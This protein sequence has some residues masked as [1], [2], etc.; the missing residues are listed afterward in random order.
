MSSDIVLR[1]AAQAKAASPETTADLDG[2]FRI[3][4][5]QLLRYFARRLGPEDA[6]DLA[7]ETFLR[8]A[9]LAAPQALDNPAAYLQRIARNLLRDR[10]KNATAARERTHLT[11]EPELHAANDGDPH[12]ALVARQTLERYEAA[13]MKLKPKTREIYLRHR[14]DGVSYEL[15]AQEWN[16]SVSGI[17]KQMMKAMAHIDRH[18]SRR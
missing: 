17:E 1:K 4:G 5:P 15:I 3:E 13:L 10:A 14:L 7:Q 2:L 16:M 6:K 11:L 9:S 8:F 12:Q 18:L